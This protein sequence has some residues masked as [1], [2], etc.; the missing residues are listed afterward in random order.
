[1]YRNNTSFNKIL[2]Y[3]FVYM[4]T[5]TLYATIQV[6]I[7]SQ[8]VALNDSHLCRCVEIKAFEPVFVWRGDSPP[9]GW[10]YHP[11]EPWFQGKLL[12]KRYGYVPIWVR[13]R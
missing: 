6:I 13:N 10:G 12:G 8:F 9:G 11:L 5:H 7:T 3:V 4:N 2:T 1:M